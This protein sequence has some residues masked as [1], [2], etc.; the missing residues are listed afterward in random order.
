MRIANIEAHS[1]IQCE[2]TLLFVCC[3][4]AAL[5][6]LEMRN[7][8]VWIALRKEVEVVVTYFKLFSQHS[9]G[10]TGQYRERIHMQDT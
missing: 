2:I 4:R 8:V 6:Q 3:D 10:V 5:Y 1:E 7:S 9:S